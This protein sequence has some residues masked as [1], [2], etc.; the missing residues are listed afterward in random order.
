MKEHGPIAGT[1]K[2]CE[3]TLESG[4]VQRTGPDRNVD[5]LHA[6]LV[7]H[8]LLVNWTRLHGVPDVEHDATSSFL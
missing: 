7:D 2:Y 3:Y 5:V 6:E 8:S 4:I 1:S